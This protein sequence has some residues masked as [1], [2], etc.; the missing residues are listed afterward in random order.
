MDLQ[1][2]GGGCED[3][4]ELAQD[5]DRWWALVS[6]VMNLRVPQM[7]GIS[8]IAAEPVSFSRRTLLHGVIKYYIKTCHTTQTALRS[9]QAEY[10]ECGGCLIKIYLAN[11]HLRILHFSFSIKYVTQHSLLGKQLSKKKDVN[12]KRQ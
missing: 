10:Y 2:V 8:L 9:R 12:S 4:M 1:Q 3:W 6:T 5:R 7:R 11:N